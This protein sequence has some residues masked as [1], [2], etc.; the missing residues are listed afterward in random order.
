MS[1]INLQNTEIKLPGRKE[2]IL[3]PKVYVHFALEITM[4]TYG[5]VS[6]YLQE[7]LS[8][9]PE[10][11]SLHVWPQPGGKVQYKL[12]DGAPVMVAT[13]FPG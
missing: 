9:L 6:L 1:A 11:V 3:K 2:I 10:P 7:T 12:M 4:I 5:K 13:V 8:Q